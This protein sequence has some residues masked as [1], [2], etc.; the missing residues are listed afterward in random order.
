MIVHT[1]LVILSLASIAGAAADEVEDP[2]NETRDE[3]G[4]PNTVA[5]GHT[6]P[7]GTSFV[8]GT[9]ASASIEIRVVY[10]LVATSGHRA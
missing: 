1:G 8:L 7:A 9:E 6:T 3:D 10:D 2:Y 4:R 5:R